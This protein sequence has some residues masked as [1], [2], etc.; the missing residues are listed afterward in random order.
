M[1][2]Q[3]PPKVHRQRTQRVAQKRAPRAGTSQTGLPVVA[4]ASHL[5]VLRSN[6][7]HGAVPFLFATLG[8]A[9]IIAPQSMDAVFTGWVLALSAVSL[10]RLMIVLRLWPE[11][12]AGAGAVRWNT[13]LLGLL[14]CLYGL[15]PLWLGVNADPWFLAFVDLWLI[16]TAF[17]VLLSQGIVWRAG[18]AFAVP[19]VLPIV[20]FLMFSGVPVL[21]VLGIGDVVLC[22]YLFSVVR[23]TRAAF[24]EETLHR[25]GFERMAEHQAL[26]R[27]R[28]ERLVTELTEEIERRK[29]AEAAL[30]QARDAAEHMS[31][32]DHLTSL[33]N[34]RVFDRELARAWS[35]AARNRVPTSVIACDID[36]FRSYNEHFGTYGGD[37]C[38]VLVGE[39]IARAL[40]G[41]EGLACRDSGDQFSILLP[42]RSEGDALELAESIRAGIHDLTIMHPGAVVERVVTASFGVATLTSDASL[43]PSAL[44]ESADQAL[45]RAKRCGGNCVFAIYGDLASDER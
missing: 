27:R 29:V 35:R 41:T 21:V 17:A 13:L 12:A 5:V 18:L 16:G 22:A 44:A 11:G 8:L 3:L 10:A 25:L 39:A 14:G 1:N 34:R 32:Q 15:T 7:R 19:A 28:S 30:K 26:Q 36:L 24:I 42:N 40:N 9:L 45:R 31:N 20:G 4:T 2:H 33:A 38:L 37:C 6:A 23:R 43:G